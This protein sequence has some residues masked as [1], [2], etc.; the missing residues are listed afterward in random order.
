MNHKRPYS[1]VELFERNKEISYAGD[2]SVAKFPLGGIG[3][4]NISVGPRGELR[5][6][7][8]FNWP[9]KNQF[10]P[11]SFFAIWTKEPG[12]EPISRILE[13]KLRPPFYKSHGFLNGE[14]AGLP[15][16]ENSKM[17]GKQPFVYVDLQ[18]SQ[19]PVKVRMEAFT[20]FIPLDADNSGIPAAIIRYRVSNPTNGP[21]EVSV[22]GTLANVVGFDGYDVFNNVKLVD[23]VQNEYREKDGVNGWYYTAKNL[24]PTDM[25]YGSMSIV[26]TAVRE[27]DS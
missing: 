20:P 5:D 23:E 19:L 24:K 8:I 13:S 18:D 9:G 27:C 26:T 3:T 2:A 25:K 14:L 4:G 1:K 6:W 11:F 7:E 12:A 15:R 16:F 22:L 17:V 10:V 21:V